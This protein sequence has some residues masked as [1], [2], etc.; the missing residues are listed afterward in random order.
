VGLPDDHVWCTAELTNAYGRTVF[1][2]L[3]SEEIFTAPAAS[4]T[5]GFVRCTRPLSTRGLLCEDMRMEFASGRLLRLDAR[6]DAQRDSLLAHIDVDQGGRRLG[7]VALVD[8]D[9]RVGGTGRIYWNTLL[10][11]NQTCH[12]A[13]GL[14]FPDCRREG[15]RSADLNESRTHIDVMIGGPEVEV[16]GTTASG[17]KVPL[18]V[19]GVWRA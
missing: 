10:D 1:R 3:P 13:L 8:T 18:I 2:N 5:E 11:E 17:E 4:A 12:M 19:D 16:S 7:E 15:G 6:T 9:S 14:G